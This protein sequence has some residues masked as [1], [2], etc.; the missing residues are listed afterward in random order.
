LHKTVGSE[1]SYKIRVE[2]LP[3]K[4]TFAVGKGECPL[5]TPTILSANAKP[6]EE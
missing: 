4:K 2:A 5:F 6:A 3:L 1:G